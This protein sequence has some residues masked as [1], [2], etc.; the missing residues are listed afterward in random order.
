MQRR[1][2]LATGVLLLAALAQPLSAAPKR[3]LVYTRNYTPDGKG[4]IHAN[5][6]DSVAAIRK[7][8]EEH[9]FLVDHSDDPELF[10]PAKLQNY[11]AIVFSNSNNEAFT[12]DTQRQAFQAYIRGGGG[13]VGIHAA[14]A[15]ER[16]WEWYWK[17]IGGSFDYHPP[18]QKFTV[19]VVDR[20]HPSTKGLPA[21]FEWEDE[22]YFQKHTNPDVKPLLV[23]DPGQLNDPNKAE[24]PANPFG[25]SVPL[26]WYHYFEGGRVYYLA[27]GHKNEHYQNPLMLQQILGGI[28]WA[29]D[30]GNKESSQ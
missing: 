8:G 30:R 5:I 20:R 7:L 6:A 28:E 3:V 25:D 27:L 26:A 9:G 12:N 13:F 23:A 4:Y 11:D 10:T 15:S 24:R 17:M 19:R 29:M 14:S 22:F 16:E 18:L 2:V 21:S 1:F